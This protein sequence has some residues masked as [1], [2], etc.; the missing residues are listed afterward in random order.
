MKKVLITG[1][2]PFGKDTVNPSWEAVS[3][4][5]DQTEYAV[6]AKRKMP[7]EYDRVAVL[8]DAAIKEEQPDAVICVGQAGGRAELT[9]EMVAINIKDARIADNA[10]VLCSGEAICEE[11]PAAY[12]ATVPVKR[13]AAAMREAG[14][15]ASV[16]YTAGTY[17]CNNI[18]YHL[19]HMLEHRYPHIKGGFIH[20]PFDCGQ[21]LMRPAGTP[22]LP[23]ELMAKGLE[24]A[25]DAVA[26]VLEKNNGDLAGATGETH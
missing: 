3:I 16:S 24:A 25:V 15:P 8:L 17:V 20:I 9:P 22:S 13:M 11:G 23:L 18:M 4:L 12:F 19:M 5:P 1:F 14:V 6:I 2:E 7:V 26:E 10:G 21:V